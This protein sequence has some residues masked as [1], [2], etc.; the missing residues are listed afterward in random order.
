MQPA[1]PKHTITEPSHRLRRHLP[2]YRMMAVCLAA[3]GLTFGQLLPPWIDRAGAT[4]HSN[5][6]RHV[7]ETRIQ[8]WIDAPA[9][10][11]ALRRQNDANRSLTQ[12]DIE[13][14]DAQWRQETLAAERP[15]IQAVLST[16]LSRFLREIQTQHRGLFTEIFVVDNRGLNVG[17]SDM[18]SDYWQGDE[19]KWQRTFL[20]GPDAVFIDR[21]EED[22]STQQFQS[23]VSLSITDPQTGQVIGSMTVG[24][25]VDRA[26]DLLP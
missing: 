20:V 23:Q 21:V 9:I 18:T 13:R 12:T 10:I 26:L 14:L 1:R 11:E 16:D 4:D 8:S 6:V 17:Q 24:V 25:D 19:Y 7:A 3:V 15:L 5:A 2:E 22:E